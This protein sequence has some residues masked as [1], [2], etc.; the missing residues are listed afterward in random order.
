MIRITDDE[1]GRSCNM[2]RR[3]EKLKDVLVGKHEGKRYQD[4]L[5]QW[6]STW[7]TRKYP[8]GM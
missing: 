2:Y 1:M 3:K 7:G 4:Y 5:D 6:S 8:M